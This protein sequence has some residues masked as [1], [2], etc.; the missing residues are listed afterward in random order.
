MRAQERGRRLGMTWRWHG[1]VFGGGWALCRGWLP[2][3]SLA[4]AL[5]FLL[6]WN[7]RF[8]LAW[9]CLFLA[10]LLLGSVS[11]GGQ[12]GDAAIRLEPVIL[13]IV[14]FGSVALATAALQVAARWTGAAS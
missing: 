7:G 6:A 1:F 5:P 12:E 14:V 2:A 10:H 4:I 13:P 9:A 8:Y 3:G 11:I